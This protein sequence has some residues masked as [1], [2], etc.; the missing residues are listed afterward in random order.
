MC[1]KENRYIS[2]EIINDLLIKYHCPVPDHQFRAI[3]IGYIISPLNPPPP[4]EIIKNIWGGNLPN[5]E[6][7]DAFSFFM[8]NVFMHYWNSLTD[9][10]NLKIRFIFKEIKVKNTAKNLSEL[11]RIRREEIGGLLFGVMSGDENINFSKQIQKSIAHLEEIWGYFE[12]THELIKKNGVGKTPKEVANMIFLL[13]DME[14]IA[15]IE[16]NDLIE[17][18]SNER[19]SNH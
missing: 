10:R 6:D 14:K 9:H 7:I 19:I 11:C 1:A 5:F 16:I 2:A 15:Q 17:N 18:C 8:N 4:G 3:L 12:A 13:K